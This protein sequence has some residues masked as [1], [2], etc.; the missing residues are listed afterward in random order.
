MRRPS[1]T[2]GPRKLRIEVRLA[3]SYDA[4][5]IKGTLSDRVTPLI[6]SAMNRACFSLSITHGPA[7]R[8]K[9]PEPMLTPS[10]GKKIKKKIFNPKSAPRSQKKQLPEKNSHSPIFFF[11]AR[12]DGCDSVARILSARHFNRPM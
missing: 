4:L 2:P 6:T 5:K 3:L 10:T 12:K 8:N 7:I 1:A 9:L 11:L